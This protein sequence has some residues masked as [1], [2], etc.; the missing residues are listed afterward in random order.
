[1]VSHMLMPIC[2][3]RL[4]PDIT[5]PINTLIATSS[6][7]FS[8]ADPVVD[9]VADAAAGLP[10][11]YTR[12]PDPVAGAVPDALRAQCSYWSGNFA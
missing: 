10:A 1:M 2:V 4:C 7:L 6:F 5:T 3:M 11:V 9:P 12:C 8:A